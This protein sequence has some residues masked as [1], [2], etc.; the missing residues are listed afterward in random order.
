[1][2]LHGVNSPEK[3]HPAG[4]D[5]KEFV[6]ALIEGKE[7]VLQSYKDTMSFTRWVCDVDYDG[8][9]LTDAIIDAGH[10]VLFDP[11]KD[12]WTR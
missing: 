12:K 11:K 3:N 9:S 1:M 10:G 8:H 7:V 6:K 5:A 2:R 4:K